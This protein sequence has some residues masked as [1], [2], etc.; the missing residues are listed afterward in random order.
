[1][2]LRTRDHLNESNSS[3]VTWAFRSTLQV[4]SSF[5]FQ[6]SRSRISNRVTFRDSARRCTVSKRIVLRERTWRR[7]YLQL[8]SQ[9]RFGV[10][11]ELGAKLGRSWSQVG[12]RLRQMGDEEAGLVLFRPRSL[13]RGAM[14][15]RRDAN[16]TLSRRVS[17]GRPQGSGVLRFLHHM[18]R[19]AYFYAKIGRR[20]SATSTAFTSKVKS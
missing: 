11:E 6:S 1:M 2:S 12:A 13:K 15:R 17:L 16:A 4:P 20:G 9:K 19:Y 8:P 18:P 5:G 7:R 10:S 3:V 14:G